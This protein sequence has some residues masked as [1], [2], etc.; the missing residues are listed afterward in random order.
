MVCGSF[1]FQVYVHCILYIYIFGIFNSYFHYQFFYIYY[2]ILKKGACRHWVRN[3]FWYVRV[4]VRV[5]LYT[6]YNC[7][8][9][10]TYVTVKM[11]WAHM[12]PLQGLALHQTFRK[13]ILH[14]IKVSLDKP[15]HIDFDVLLLPGVLDSSWRRSNWFQHQF[16]NKWT[17]VHERWFV[18]IDDQ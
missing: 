3:I 2:C 1:R 16:K 6:T 4:T 17:Y 15:E 7:I 18:L 10:I 12:P 11:S 5:S 14:V 13:K 8:P 9:I